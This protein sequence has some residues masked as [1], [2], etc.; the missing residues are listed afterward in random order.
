MKT[1]R[2]DVLS[3]KGQIDW[4]RCRAR[5][6]HEDGLLNDRTNI[7]LVVNGILAAAAAL[8][9]ANR[10][11]VIIGI[12]SILANLL[13]LSTG[14][15]TASVIRSLTANYIEKADDPVDKIVRESIKCWPGM[16][17]CTYILGIYMPALVLF[18][19]LIGFIT[20]A[21]RL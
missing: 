20:L 18:G 3:S 19:W 15:Q 11:A 2:E 1:D 8:T 7:Y 21:N 4:V 14:I 16:F 6:E 5:I 13:W 17:R 12:V 9:H 10:I